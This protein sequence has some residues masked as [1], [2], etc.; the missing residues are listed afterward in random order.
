MVKFMKVRNLLTLFVYD[1]IV[2]QTKP[3]ENKEFYTF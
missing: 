1:L 2:S 3:L